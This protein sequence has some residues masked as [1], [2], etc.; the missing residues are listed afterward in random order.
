MMHSY[1]V[2][3]YHDLLWWFLLYIYHIILLYTNYCFSRMISIYMLKYFSQNL[4]FYTQCLQS[5][6]QH[7]LLSV[8]LCSMRLQKKGGEGMRNI[9]NSFRGHIYHILLLLQLFTKHTKACLTDEHG[10]QIR[11]KPRSAV[12]LHV[13][14]HAYVYSFDKTY[15]NV[16]KENA[17]KK[18]MNA[19]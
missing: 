17:S 8:C 15:V 9:L 18:W 13:F 4:S 2:D 5:F 16:N 10:K 3:W 6:M 12:E 19:A 11:M 7:N 1:S 14:G